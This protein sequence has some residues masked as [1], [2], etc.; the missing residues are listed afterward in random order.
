MPK[1]EQLKDPTPC[2]L[3]RTH[4]GVSIILLLVV[5]D[6]TFGLLWVAVLYLTWGH[7]VCRVPFKDVS[8]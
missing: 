6:D 2:R 3:H 8:T 1:Q 4:V 7:V 5:V